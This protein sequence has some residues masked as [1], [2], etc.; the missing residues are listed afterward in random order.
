[1]LAVFGEVEKD[2][3]AVDVE[4]VQLR[5]LISKDRIR[6]TVN[7]REQKCASIASLL[8][9]GICKIGLQILDAFLSPE[10]L[11]IIT[12][13]LTQVRKNTECKLSQIQMH[14]RSLI[15]YLEQ[16]VDQA[17]VVEILLKEIE[18]RS[19]QNGLHCCDSSFI[20][21]VDLDHFHQILV[22][23]EL[24]NVFWDQGK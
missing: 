5:S 6:Q 7:D 23:A 16:Y 18:F 13:V 9:F 2:V 21:G 1:M 8:D 11:L 12:I 3:D 4:E 15:D 19:L 22:R 17:A 10:L 24:V 20:V 14:L